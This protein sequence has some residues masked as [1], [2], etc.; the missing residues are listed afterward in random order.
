MHCTDHQRLVAELD[1]LLEQI[2]TLLQ[3][4]ENSGLQAML[5]TD[6]LALRALQAQASEQRRTHLLALGTDS[7][8]AHHTPTP[9]NPLH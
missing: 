1:T 9:A 7:P 3:R 6:Y 5:K 4:F 2:A 8:P